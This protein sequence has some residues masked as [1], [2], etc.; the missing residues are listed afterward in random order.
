VR[1]WEQLVA[2]GAVAAG[3]VVVLAEVRNGAVD[4]GDGAVLI[5]ALVL[6]ARAALRLASGS[7][8]QQNR[9]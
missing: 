5:G 9:E 1:E 3:A 7:P 6:F 8:S 4:I 2:S